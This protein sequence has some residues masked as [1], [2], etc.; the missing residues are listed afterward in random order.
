MMMAVLAVSGRPRRMRHTSVPLMIGR[1]ISRMT[2]SGAVSVTVR[3]AVSPLPTTS[4]CASPERSSACLISAAISCSSSTTRTRGTRLIAPQPT[5]AGF[6]PDDAQVNSELS[7]R[8]SVVGTW[9]VHVPASA[10]ANTGLGLHRRHVGHLQEP[11]A[12]PLAGLEVTQRMVD[13]LDD[14]L[15]DG[16]GQGSEAIMDPE[17]LPTALH[18]PGPAQVRQVSGHGGLWET[19]TAMDVADTDLSGL[20]QREDAQ[21]RAVGERLEERF[22]RRECFIGGHIFAL[23]NISQRLIFALAYIFHRREHRRKH[24]RDQR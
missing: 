17:A 8:R 5:C 3:S 23:T 10:T 21:P 11:P 24:R 19:Q 9:H 20:Q 18:Q 14:G 6:R 2:R 7:L 4:T 12:V 15:R 22:E 16:I 1:L 13:S